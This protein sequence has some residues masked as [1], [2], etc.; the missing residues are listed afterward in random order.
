MKG[1]SYDLRQAKPQE[2]ARAE[3]VKS[4]EVRENGKAKQT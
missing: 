4:K 3:R 2:R 1:N